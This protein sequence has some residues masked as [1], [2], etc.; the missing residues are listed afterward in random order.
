MK[1][2]WI[3]LVLLIIFGFFS[4]LILKPYLSY[5]IFAII[6][7]FFTY[8]LYKKI[9]IKLRNKSLSAIILIISMLLIVI[10]P[11]FY[12][13]TTLLSQTRDV[14]QSLGSVE[15][16]KLKNFEERISSTVGIKLNVAE[17]IS[18]AVTDLSTTA[19]SYIVGNIPKVTKAVANIFIGFTIMVFTMFYLYVD[20]DRIVSRLKELIPL[21]EK[22]RNHFFNRTYSIVKALFLGIFLIAL[23]QGVVATI[24][25]FIFKVPSPIFWGVVTTI[26]AS[27]PILGPPWIYIPLSLYLLYKGSLFGFVGLLLYGVIIVSQIDNFIRPRFVGRRVGIH[28]LTIILGVIGGVVFFGFPGFIMGPLILAL[29]LELLAAYRKRS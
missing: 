27:I 17:K 3:L 8:P 26:F 19:V 11:S 4:F 23:V 2:E 16:E 13:S 28:P 1:A 18:E 6:L 10:V 29:F 20:G 9:Q 14:L 15:L 25:Y 22:Y 21:E 12:I 5:I 7:I 24:G